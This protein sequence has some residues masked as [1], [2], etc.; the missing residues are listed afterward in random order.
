MS[1]YALSLLMAVI[2]CVIG[3][4]FGGM[5]L[6]R[7]LADVGVQ[8][9]GPDNRVQARAFGG[10]LVLAHGGAAL[11][12]GYQPSVGAAM[13]F[14]LALAWFGSALGRVV[15]IRRDGVSARAETGNLVFEILIGLTLSLP[16]FNAGRLVLHGGM[17][18]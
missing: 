9:A 15:A 14:A 3:G 5:A 2:A 7:P 8:A 1:N 6:A 18:A 10:L 11:Y 13:A 12:L 16:F 4:A 17:I